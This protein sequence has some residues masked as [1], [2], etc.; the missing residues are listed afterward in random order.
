LGTK[1]ADTDDSL[2]AM[3]A[4][5]EDKENQAKRLEELRQKKKAEEQKRLEEIETLKAEQRKKI[6]A[7][8]RKDI[9]KYEAIVSSEYGKDMKEAAWN[10][11]IN[12][13]PKAGKITT[14]DIKNLKIMYKIPYVNLRSSY[15]DLSVSQVQSMSNISIRSK[16]DW[17]FYGHSTIKHNYNLKSINGDKV[18]IDHAT[19]LMWHHGSDNFIMWKKAKRWV[20]KL[21]RKG[22]AGYND[23][24]LPT[25][26]E[27]VSLLESSKRTR[28][29]YS[30]SP[31]YIDPIFSNI[32]EWILTGDK[33]G[34][35]AAWGVHFNNGGVYRNSIHS[36]GYHV[37]P[38]RSV[39]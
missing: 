21:N 27:A 19:G 17:G 10:N 25:V 30:A 8:M 12:R 36:G 13:Y 32:H 26:E 7:A 11:L 23:W 22:Y 29:Y 15:R 14:G 2:D 33:H 5:V 16:E 31:L 18:V 35:E 6:H 34:S 24:R 39:E 3:F 9:R 38:V 20:E 28:N 1:A 4:M 37:R